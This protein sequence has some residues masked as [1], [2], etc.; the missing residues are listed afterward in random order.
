M[1]TALV[2]TL[3][4]LFGF[5]YDKK[6]EEKYCAISDALNFYFNPF[7][8]ETDEYMR[9]LLLSA[10]KETRYIYCKDLIIL[11]KMIEIG[12]SFGGI[13]EDDIAKVGNINANFEADLASLAIRT[14]VPFNP[15]S[16]RIERTIRVSGFNEEADE[17]SQRQFFESIFNDVNY[18]TLVKTLEDGHYIYNGITIVELG[19]K[20]SA[21]E[22]VERK[23]AYADGVLDV[24]LMSDYIKQ[25]EAEAHQKP[26]P[27]RPIK[28]E[29]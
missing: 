10:D 16:H 27:K 4:N 20:E 13:S 11:P 19:S 24:V 28:R 14:K 3:A 29:N 7:T 1:S 8:I 9:N 17:E 23:I 15:D 2:N 21:D 5:S 12:K 6:H 25:K 18:I 22:A 26:V